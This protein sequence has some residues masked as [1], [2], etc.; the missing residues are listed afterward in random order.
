MNIISELNMEKKIQTIKYCYTY[1]TKHCIIKLFNDDL[2]EFLLVQPLMNSSKLCISVTCF[3]NLLRS[4]QLTK[5]KNGSFVPDISVLS[6]RGECTPHRTDDK[7]LLRFL[8]CR[9][10]SLEGA[11]KL[12]IINYNNSLWNTE[13]KY[14][15]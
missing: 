5:S 4:I 6:G 11:H 9:N 8:R 15:N 7:Y 1:R 13:I 14:S 3:E 12:V 10:F 2:N